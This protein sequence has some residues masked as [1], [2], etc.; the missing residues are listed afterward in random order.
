MTT[1]TTPAGCALAALLAL[2]LSG[3][4]APTAPD[5]ARKVAR[6]EAYAPTGTFI[7]R[8]N[9]QGLGAA[10]ITAVDRNAVE[11]ARATQSNGVAGHPAL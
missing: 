9:G 1:P 7:P 3:C 2:S 4:A 11:N 8:K 10:P 6:D 5:G